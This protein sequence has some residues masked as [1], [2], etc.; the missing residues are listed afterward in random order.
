[1]PCYECIRRFRNTIRT[2]LKPHQTLIH[3]CSI[4]LSGCGSFADS[5]KKGFTI[6]NNPPVLTRFLRPDIIIYRFMGFFNGCPILKLISSLAVY[7]FC[8]FWHAVIEIMSWVFNSLLLCSVTWQEPQCCRQVA[9][10]WTWRFVFKLLRI[11]TFL[12]WFLFA[13]ILNLGQLYLI[14]LWVWLT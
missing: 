10:E 1:M 8:W 2:H 5:D 7:P 12:F 3:M 6:S 14:F 13:R 4:Y 9:L 11:N